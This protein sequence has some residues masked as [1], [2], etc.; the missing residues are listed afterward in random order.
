MHKKTGAAHRC[1][2]CDEKGLLFSAEDMSRHNTVDKVVGMALK[3]KIDLHNVYLI[4]TGRIPIEIIE[5]LCYGGIPMIIARSYPTYNALELA[6]EK[7]ITLIG[8]AK[9]DSI[10][11]YN[12]QSRIIMQDYNCF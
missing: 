8:N 7:N 5:K 4:F 2:M 6:R 9:N 1:V 11:V 12:G 3:D 10:H